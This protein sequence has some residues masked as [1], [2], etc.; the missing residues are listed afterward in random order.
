MNKE[1]ILDLMKKGCNCSQ[2]V[3]LY[4]AK[5]FKLDEDVAFKISK[6]FESGMFNGDTCGAVSGALM[7]IGLA[8]SD[9]SLENREYLKKKTREFYNKFEKSNNSIKCS[10]ILGT[11]ITNG[12]NFKRALEEGVIHEKCPKAINS[13]FEILEDMLAKDGIKVG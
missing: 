7:V 8:Y 10:E 1:I 6:A 9:S 4:F 2:T 11:N 5:T 13:A 3:L 12:D